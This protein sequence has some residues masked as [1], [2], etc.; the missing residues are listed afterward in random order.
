[1]QT[2]HVSDPSPALIN[3]LSCVHHQH[4]PIILTA[5]GQAPTVLMDFAEFERYQ[6][7]QKLQSKPTW[8]T[9]FDAL[10]EFEE[11]FKLE[12]SEQGEQIRDFVT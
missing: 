8:Q 10:N 9:M 3:A 2:I 1:M 7:W 6:Q 11:G 12:R 4:N 5:T